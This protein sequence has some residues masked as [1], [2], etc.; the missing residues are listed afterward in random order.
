MSTQFCGE[1]EVWSKEPIHSTPKEDC[2]K[3]VRE[4]HRTERTRPERERKHTERMKRYLADQAKDDFKKAYKRFKRLLQRIN[5]DLKKDVNQDDIFTFLEEVRVAHDEAIAAYG[6]VKPY[7][8]SNDSIYQKGSH[9]VTAC[10]QDAIDLLNKIIDEKDQAEFNA[11][12]RRRDLRNLKKAYANSIYSDKTESKQSQPRTQ[13]DRSKHSQNQSLR[14]HS[15]APSYKEGSQC[16]QTQRIK[17]HPKVSLYGEMSQAGSLR[18][19]LA[20]LA[21]EEKDQHFQYF[22][23]HLDAPPYEEGSQRSQ[24]QRIR[25]HSESSLYRKGSQA[26]S[27]KD[28]LATLPHEERS[29]RFQSQRE[30]SDAIPYNKENHYPPN[31]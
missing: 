13:E 28:H 14:E 27:L 12:Q 16:S 4:G 10:C 22:R 23:E 18:D 24:I 15:V 11:A 25:E 26:R 29:Q 7:E 8:D 17:E 5:E 30:P 31:S 20:T 19:H 21:H 2:E 6:K 1:D 9:T 3:S